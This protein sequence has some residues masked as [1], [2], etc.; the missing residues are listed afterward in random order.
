MSKKKP[1]PIP[2]WLWWSLGINPND[3]GDWPLMSNLAEEVN[4]WWISELQYKGVR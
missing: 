2:D 1:L 3:P 4:E